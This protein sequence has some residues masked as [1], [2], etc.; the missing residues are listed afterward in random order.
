M[1]DVIKII[2]NVITKKEVYGVVLILAISYFIYQTIVIILEDV[3]NKGK[4]KYEQ[5]KRLTITK[6]FKNISK[7]KIINTFYGVS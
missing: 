1:K 4:S 6:L 5:K 3:I 2:L 7:L